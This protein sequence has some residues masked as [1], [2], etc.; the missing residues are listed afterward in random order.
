MKIKNY[1]EEQINYNRWKYAFKNPERYLPDHWP[2]YFK[3][4]K[5]ARFG[6]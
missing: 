6:A 3:K 1:G 4:L 2:A 5:D